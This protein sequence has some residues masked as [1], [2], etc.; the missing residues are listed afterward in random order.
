M[1]ELGSLGPAIEWTRDTAQG[2]W[3]WQSVSWPAKY[4]PGSYIFYFQDSRDA[5]AFA[6]KY[7]HEH[8]SNS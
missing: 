1:L 2:D 7:T 8:T 3:A 5:M 4:D 6:L